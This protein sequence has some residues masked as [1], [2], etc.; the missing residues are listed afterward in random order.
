MSVQCGRELN[1]LHSAITVIILHG[2]ILILY[3]WKPY[4]SITPRI[5][6]HGYFINI[7]KCICFQQIVNTVPIPP[8]FLSLTA[9]IKD[10]PP[11]HSR[12][13]NL[14]TIKVFIYQLM[15]NRFCFKRI[16]KFKL[17]QL[18]QV[19]VQSPSSGS[20]FFEVAEVVVIKIVN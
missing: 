14:Y 16:L 1:F 15:H 10:P 7:I 3:N 17:K 5:Y 4:L 11:P 8:S 18:L 2:Q 12:T 19:S 6:N 20:L 13:V 9:L